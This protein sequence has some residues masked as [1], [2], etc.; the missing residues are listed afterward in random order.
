MFHYL[1]FS[2]PLGVAIARNMVALIDDGNFVS[3]LS[4]FSSD[5]CACKTCAYDK[6]FFHKYAFILKK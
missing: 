1:G 6:K 2:V 5:N 4:Q 3:C